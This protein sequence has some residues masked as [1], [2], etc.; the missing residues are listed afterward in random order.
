M[1]K[2]AAELMA[3]LA[4]DS[5]YQ[6]RMKVQDEHF[7]RLEKI[8]AD[9]EKQLIEELSGAGF[10]VESVWD[11]VNSENNY[12]GAESI[13]LKH[14]KCEHHPK[15]L[16]GIA[17]SLA[18]PE[19]SGNDELWDLLVNLYKETSPNSEIDV[20]ENRGAQEAVAIALECLATKSR[21]GILE[22]LVSEAPSGD[23]IEYLKAKLELLR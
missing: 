7:S 16:A 21:F 8:Y 9:D 22:K 13:L 11:F 18:I 12:S 20:P 6:A 15:T 23:G 5:D 1:S 3:E 2:T 17:R 10:S 4:E 14:L 19:F